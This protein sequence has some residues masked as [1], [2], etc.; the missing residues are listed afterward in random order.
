[1]YVLLNFILASILDF[2][3]KYD[4]F[5]IHIDFVHGMKI[6]DMIKLQTLQKAGK[7]LL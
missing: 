1:M 6:N 2:L 4:Y 3:S 7:H 5:H